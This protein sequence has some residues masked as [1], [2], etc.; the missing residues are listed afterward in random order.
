MTDPQ[1]LERVNA[2]QSDLEQLLGLD[3]D[4]EIAVT[5]YDDEDSEIEGYSLVLTEDAAKRVV[6]MLRVKRA[7]PDMERTAY[8]T[9]NEVAG[10]LRY[11]LSKVHKDIAAKKIP[12]IRVGRSIRVPVA[13]FEAWLEAN[14]VSGEIADR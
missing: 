12:S 5:V 9:A 13:L 6:E 10:L 1:Q 7:A 8:Y 2:L 11:S 4:S 3:A 14:T